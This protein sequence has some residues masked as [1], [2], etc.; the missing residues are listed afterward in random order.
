MALFIF[1][2][3]ARVFVW[4]KCCVGIAAVAVVVADVVRVVVPRDL[5]VKAIIVAIDKIN[6]LT[7]RVPQIYM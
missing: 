3:S 7:R 1:I 6:D 5:A 2:M 4:K